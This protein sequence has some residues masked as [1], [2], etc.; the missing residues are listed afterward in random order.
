MRRSGPQGNHHAHPPRRRTGRKQAWGLLLLTWLVFPLAA[1]AQLDQREIDYEAVID[2]GFRRGGTVLNLAGKK[3]GDEGLKILLARG[4]QLKK[5]KKLDL[6]YNELS[7]EAGRI[8]AESQAFP[9]LV[10]LELRHNFLMDAG[11]VALAG[12]TG[13]PRLEKLGLGWNE[14]RDAGALA[15]ARSTRFPRLK[16]LDLRGNFLADATKQELKK[17]LSH[18]KSLKLEASL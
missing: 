3:I 5:V 16:K 1:G 12:A 11:T 17:K 6:R 8:L 13:F 10:A 14:V 2:A 7:E 9:N 4:P 18:L 15:L